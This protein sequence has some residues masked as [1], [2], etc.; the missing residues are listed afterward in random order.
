MKVNNM[1]VSHN[2]IKLKSY[3]SIGNQKH[4]KFWYKSHIY[5]EGCKRLGLDWTI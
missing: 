2:I 4:Y 1:K 3:N 5:I